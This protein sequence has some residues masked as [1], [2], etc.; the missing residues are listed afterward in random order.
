[1]NADVRRR[2]VAIA[3]TALLVIVAIGAIIWAMLLPEPWRDV[4][5]NATNGTDAQLSSG[6]EHPEF[7]GPDKYDLLNAWNNLHT[8]LGRE[9]L[10][11]GVVTDDELAEVR[12]AYN[13]CLS[14]YGLQ[15]QPVDGGGGEVIV[16]VRGS[17]GSQE[18]NEIIRQ[19]GVESDYVTLRDVASKDGGHPSLS[20][21]MP[22]L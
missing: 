6:S 5:Y 4:P 9:V 3:S 21:E 22:G 10:E 1:M 11:D 20:V 8:G 18:K 16:T 2:V 14:V 7:T 13:E 15:A 12:T 17:I 19:C